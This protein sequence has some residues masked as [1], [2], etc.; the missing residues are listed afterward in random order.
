MA[1]RNAGGPLYLWS[2]KQGPRKY[3]TREDFNY[4]AQT[5][6]THGNKLKEAW[7]HKGSLHII[8][9]ESEA[10]LI[11]LGGVNEVASAFAYNYDGSRVITASSKGLIT[12]WDS[13]NGEK[14]RSFETDKY[15]ITSITFS[16]DGKQIVTGLS[17][18]TVRVWDSG[19][20]K[21]LATF[22]GHKEEIKNVEYSKNDKFII[23]TTANNNIK[24]WKRPKNT[25]PE[26]GYSLT[27]KACEELKRIKYDTIPTQIK[28]EALLPAGHTNPC[29]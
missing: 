5:Y 13:S 26:S 1:I 9:P 20:G 18:N 23:T 10:K 6:D 14:I 24:I 11:V 25:W 22:K 27:R 2:L 4:N 16:L 29:D 17:D 19:T 28:L 15:P 8:D 12:I 21:L 3:N 7:K